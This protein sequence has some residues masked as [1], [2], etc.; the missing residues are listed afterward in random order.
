MFPGYYRHM[1][2][3]PHGSF[4]PFREN[5][6]SAVAE[7]LVHK[8]KEKIE[9]EDQSYLLNVNAAEYL[10]HI[11]AEFSIEPLTIDFDNPTVSAREETVRAER[12]D[13]LRGINAGDSYNVH[14]VTYHLPF[15]GDP[16][17]LRYQPNPASLCSHRIYLKDGEICFD[18]VDHDGRGQAIKQ[19]AKHALDCMRSNLEGLWQS[20]KSLDQTLPTRAR[21]IF[22]ARRSVVRQ[23]LGVLEALAIPLKRTGTIP[24]TFA[25]PV[26]RKKI[27]TPKP[28]APAQP[29][30]RDWVLDESIYQEILQT[31]HDTGRVF[32]RLP[33]TYAGKDEET[34][35]DHLILQLEPHFEWSSTTG[36]TFNK[37]GKTDILIRY[38]KEIVFVAECKFWRGRKPHFE[39]IDQIL[40]YLTWRESKT[41]IVYFVDTKE[42]TAPL[43]AIQESTPE[44]PCYVAFKGRQDESRFNYSFTCRETRSESYE[45]RCCAF[46]SRSHRPPSSGSRSLA[47]TGRGNGSL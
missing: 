8:M 14:I 5:S 35:R 21:D 28:S 37:S 3:Q 16:Q 42:I 29:Y 23:R 36:E 19:D 1:L 24:T 26:A 40:K 27:P 45:R 47:S 46:T 25:V 20:I 38:E 17:I 30:K 9:G 10:A 32:E 31:I 41:A 39:T 15:A 13:I 34:L 18:V 7:S 22:E 6:F 44:H 33:S 12:F 4:P 2:S 43:K 11:V